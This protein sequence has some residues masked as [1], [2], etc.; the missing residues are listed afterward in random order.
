MST[1]GPDE[2]AL[3]A[4]EAERQKR[5]AAHAALQKAFLP[6]IATRI[7]AR[8]SVGS[9]A[10]DFV[11]NGNKSIEL[12]ALLGHKSVNSDLRLLFAR[13][14]GRDWL[15]RRWASVDGRNSVYL[16]EL[17][18]EVLR[19]GIGTGIFLPSVVEDYN[20]TL[21]GCGFSE[22]QVKHLHQVLAE[23]KPE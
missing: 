8:E 22:A 18:R 11:R 5:I 19:L 21:A 2:A 23:A 7:K 10:A 16:D 4:A 14:T 9:V 1:Q 15:G 20:L 17:L 6:G 3:K 12:Q 13:L